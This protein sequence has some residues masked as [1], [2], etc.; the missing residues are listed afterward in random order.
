M[1]LWICFMWWLYAWIRSPGPKRGGGGADRHTGKDKDNEKEK[2]K[3]RQSK[4]PGPLQDGGANRRG[5]ELLQPTHRPTGRH[6]LE[7]LWKIFVFFLPFSGPHTLYTMS[8][9]LEMLFGTEDCVKYF[10]GIFTIAFNLH[11]WDFLKM[12]LSKNVKRIKAK[13]S[14]YWLKPA[15]LC[16]NSAQ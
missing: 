12:T 4:T 8:K 14:F 6:S 13:N 1:G 15:F 9:H 5:G 3:H 10:G 2:E 16:V 11:I 7:I